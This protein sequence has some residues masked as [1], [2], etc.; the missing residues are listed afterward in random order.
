MAEFVGVYAN[1]RTYSGGG[2]VPL[3]F[4]MTPC[5]YQRAYGRQWKTSS[6]ASKVE[7]CPRKEQYSLST[8]LIRKV[9]ALLYHQ[10]RFEL[11]LNHTNMYL[12]PAACQL[13][14][15]KKRKEI[16]NRK[17]NYEQFSQQYARRQHYN[18]K[19]DVTKVRRNSASSF[20]TTDIL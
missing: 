16:N 19:S 6:L 12:T 17:R 15:E 4:W 10:N 2:K 14:G 9:L 1:I 3:H 13:S 18:E 11:Q 7:M 5:G 20:N 8:N